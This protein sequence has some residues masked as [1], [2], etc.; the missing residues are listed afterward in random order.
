MARAPRP[1]ENGTPRKRARRPATPPVGA[2]WGG[3]SRL[4]EGALRQAGF[5]RIAGIDEAG[6]GAL[7]GPVV[8]AAVILPTD[9]PEDGIDDSKRLTPEQRERAYERILAG[10]V[11][12]G[13]GAVSND[14][15]DRINIFE[16]TK[17]AMAQ[18]VSALQ[19]APEFLLTDAVVLPLALPLWALIK[20][21]RRAL[22]ISA[23]SIV[24]KV[25][26]DR[27]MTEFDRS[28]PHYAFAVHKGYSTPEHLSRLKT[29][30]ACAIHRQSF[31]PVAAP[32]RHA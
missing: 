19:P 2:E 10:A 3:R 16:A 4:W 11:A 23:A 29:F 28:Y 21:D 31:R 9:F 26:R 25:T 1:A 15:I 32:F 12:V 22:P 8:A 13:V 17:R 18:A 27:L 5:E 24:A 7:A 30:G 20:G 6:R 14:E